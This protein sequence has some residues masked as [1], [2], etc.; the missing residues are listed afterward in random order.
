[1]SFHRLLQFSHSISNQL[2]TRIFSLMHKLK[3]GMTIASSS[4]NVV[5]Y[6]SSSPNAYKS[7]LFFLSFVYDVIQDVS[8]FLFWQ[9]QCVFYRNSDTKMNFWIVFLSLWSSLKSIH[10]HKESSSNP[11]QRM[12]YHK[13]INWTVKARRICHKK[14][15]AIWKNMNNGK[16]IN[17]C[18]NKFLKRWIEMG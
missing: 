18:V 6:Y 11:G 4:D 3:N 5:Y 8:L 16:W 17:C 15:I 7:A 9:V 1:M 12:S 14:Y 2:L 10:T 13:E